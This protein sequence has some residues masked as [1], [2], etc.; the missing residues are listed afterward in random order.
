MNGI[1]HKV[2]SIRVRSA[3]IALS[4]TL[5]LLGAFVGLLSAQDRNASGTSASS[6]RMADGKQWTTHNLDVDTAPSNCYDDAELSCR[7]YGRLYTW[8]SAQRGCKS[9]G[10]GWRLPTNE[11][12]RQLAEHY[13]GLLEESEERGKSTYKALMIGGSSGFKAVL[14]GGR[15][16]DGRYARLEAHGFYWT[17]SESGEATAWFYN[18]GKGMQALGRLSDGEKQRGFSV[19]CIK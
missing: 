16:L 19:R 9:L 1:Q 15:S 3:S 12:W 5:G 14:G 6:K 17:A 13:G 10:D 4:L 8:E 2:T 11:E 7:R 18:F